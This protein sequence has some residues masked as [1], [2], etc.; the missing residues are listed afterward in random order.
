[1]ILLLFVDC[2]NTSQV[3]TNVNSAE[4]TKANVAATPPVALS[5]IALALEDKLQ[6]GVDITGTN[7]NGLSARELHFLQYVPEARYGNPFDKDP[8]L[9]AFFSTCPW[10]RPNPNYDGSMLSQTDVYNYNWVQQA[11]LDGEQASTPPAPTP[12]LEK[13]FVE[14]SNLANDYWQKV[15]INCNGDYY[16]AAWNSRN[17]IF[18]ECKQK[19]EPEN[20]GQ[21]NSPRELS[22]ADK[23]NG[24][25]PLPVKYEGKSIVTLQTCRSF[26]P[27]FGGYD[28]SGKFK[29][30]WTEWFDAPQHL[31]L[32]LTKKK[33]VWTTESYSDS[34][35]ILQMTC[36]NVRDIEKRINGVGNK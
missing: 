7:L 19:S 28:S 11:A 30:S 10:Y 2:S 21:I 4:S 9:K 23:L 34:G 24:V 26:T 17:N 5:K 35:K 27:G 15:I 1:L 20:T 12:E 8:E 13:E 3:N 6:Q 14:A 32:T 36:S 18:F 25:D 31:W 16:Y 22:E 33:E 29:E